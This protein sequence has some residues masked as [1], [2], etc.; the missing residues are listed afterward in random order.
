MS[1]VEV[2]QATATLLW[3]SVGI[4]G[5]LLILWFLWQILKIG[6][7][8][9]E[10]GIDYI[11]FLRGEVHAAAKLEEIEILRPGSEKRKSKVKRILEKR[12][13]VEPK[14]DAHKP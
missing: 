5:T 3:A 1:V 13:K 2:V 10:Y 11:G 7:N 9:R 8:L 14:Q 6:R 12:K 4:I